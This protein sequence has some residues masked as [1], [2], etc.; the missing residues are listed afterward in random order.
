MITRH[1]VTTLR[2]LLFEALGTDRTV[3]ARRARDWYI[4]DLLAATLR[5]DDTDREAAFWL[6]TLSEL[7]GPF[8]GA[9]P[10]V[11]RWLDREEQRLLKLT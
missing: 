7:V 6:A 1:H 9:C 5:G 3:A 11:D 10:D 8:R 4:R 2:R